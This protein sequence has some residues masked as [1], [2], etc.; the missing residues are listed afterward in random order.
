[1]AQNRG[2]STAIN[3]QTH[4][5]LPT[6]LEFDAF[7]S[8]KAKALRIVIPGL[9]GGVTLRPS[10]VHEDASCRPSVVRDLGRGARGAGGH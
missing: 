3:A 9:R 7:I 4:E 5:N 2:T 6:S 1:M 10:L 8:P